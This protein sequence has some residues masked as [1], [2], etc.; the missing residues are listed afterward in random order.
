[1]S[2]PETYKAIVG[3]EKG[4]ISIKE[5]SLP[6]PSDNQVLVEVEFAPLNPTDFMKINGFY[7]KPADYDTALHGSEGSGVV[8]AIGQDLK[9]PFQVGDR[10]HIWVKA[11]ANM[12]W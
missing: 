11:G 10:V 1:M 7:G 8:V 9:S 5:F 3:N 6:K 2:L 12:C 4:E